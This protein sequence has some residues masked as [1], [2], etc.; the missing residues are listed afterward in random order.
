MNIIS[1]RFIN[2]RKKSSYNHDMR[3]PR[4]RHG[5]FRTPKGFH[6][7]GGD[8]PESQKPLPE[9]ILHCQLPSSVHFMKSN[10]KLETS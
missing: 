9:R 4:H 1:N 6:S 10:Y 3:K 7:R 2:S 5:G 8:L